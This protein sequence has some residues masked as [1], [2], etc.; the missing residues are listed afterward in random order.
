MKMNSVRFWFS[1]VHKVCPS[2]FA[3]DIFIYQKNERTQTHLNIYDYLFGYVGRV[4]SK[5]KSYKWM[6]DALY[7]HHY[8]YILHIICTY[9]NWSPLFLP[10]IYMYLLYISRLNPF[11]AKTI[12]LLWW[13]QFKR[14]E[15][16][17]W[18]IKVKMMMTPSWFI[19]NFVSSSPSYGTQAQA[20]QFIIIHEAYFFF[21]LD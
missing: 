9:I 8:Y 5:N 15:K 21:S 17:R 14:W 6:G 10:I 12:H 19:F 4:G 7:H 13:I 1:P 16:T 2:R 18:W 11:L 20:R 3:S